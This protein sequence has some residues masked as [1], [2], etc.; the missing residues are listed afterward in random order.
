MVPIRIDT[1]P[2]MKITTLESKGEPGKG[3]RKDIQ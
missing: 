3:G 1:V 2:K